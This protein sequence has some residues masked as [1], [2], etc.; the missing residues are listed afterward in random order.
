MFFG[1]AG[2]GDTIMLTN[3]S[4]HPWLATHRPHPTMRLSFVAAAALAIISSSVLGAQ[5]GKEPRR[6]TLAAGA[7][8]NDA[9]AYY[10]FALD[11]LSRDPE[12]AA[13][14]LYWATRLEPT[15]ADAFYARRVALLLTD[16]RRLMRYWTGDRRTI[17]SS[18]IKRID[19]LFYHALTLNPFVSQRLDRNLYDKIADEIAAKYENDGAGNAGEIRYLIDREISSFPPGVRAWF[20]YGDGRNTDALRLYAEAIQA[21][22]HNGLL[23]VERARVFYNINQPDSALAELTAGIEELRKRDTKDLIYV[24]QS[25]AVTEQSIGVVQE[26]LGHADAAREAFGRALQEDL[27]YYPAHVQLALMAVE[28]NDTTTALTEMD[29]ATQL[30]PD[31]EAARYLY[32]FTLTMSGRMD[33]GMTQLRKAIELNPVYAAPHLVLAR[34]LQASSYDDDAAAEYKAFLALS[35][36]TDMRRA[37]ARRRLAALGKGGEW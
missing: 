11:E 10:D 6:P 21:D 19:S 24:Y 13:D 9:H 34:I 36:Q 8:T 7:D 20:A 33:E 29:L 32:G 37:D 17:Q 26:R 3:S 5:R 22:K 18:D 12:K 2:D 15:W 16:P 1:L 35:A 4:V 28:A 14:A 27:S 23:R 25:K 31:D 30:R